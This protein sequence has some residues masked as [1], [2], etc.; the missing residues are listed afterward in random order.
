[1]TTLETPK[2]RRGASVCL[3]ENERSANVMRRVGMVVG[4]PPG[5]PDGEMFGSLDNPAGGGPL[6]PPLPDAGRGARARARATMRSLR[7][8]VLVP[9]PRRGGG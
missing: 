5:N 8:K 1:M 9:P 6:P 2:P 4:P 3:R 7:G